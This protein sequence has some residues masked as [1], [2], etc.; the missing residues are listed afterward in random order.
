MSDENIRSEVT[1][2]LQLNRLDLCYVRHVKHSCAIS[3]NINKSDGGIFKLTF[4]GDCMPTEFMSKIGKD[5]TLLIHE[6]TFED[7]LA[8]RAQKTSH[9]TISQ[10][11]QQG[12]SMNAKHTIL[13]HF[14]PRYNLPYLLKPLPENVSVAFDFM[15][16]VESDLDRLHYVYDMV[17]PMFANHLE[18]LKQKSERRNLMKK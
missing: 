18:D 1:K 2:A 3:L 8:D 11:I 4:S 6:A 12:V 10:A 17:K 14:G 5:S 9:S 13:T 16:I 15:E 7:Q